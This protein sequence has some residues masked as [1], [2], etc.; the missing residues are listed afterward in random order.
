MFLN[1]RNLAR[2]FILEVSERRYHHDTAFLFLLISRTDFLGYISGVHIVEYSFKANHQIV[3]L[4]AC[5][6]VFG[7]RKHTHII[8]T[9][10][11]YKHCGLRSVPS[12]SGQVF[13]D[14]SVN[15]FILNGG[16]YF[17]Y[18]LTV[19]MHSADVVIG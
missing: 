13:N 16:V 18:P 10:I 4:V 2:V 9:K 14:Y 15:A 17:I 11:V 7:Y 12:E 3:I 5:V 1:N 19:K 8:F 6:Y